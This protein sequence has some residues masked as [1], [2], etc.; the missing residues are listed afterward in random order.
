[1]RIGRAEVL[2][3]V[4]VAAMLASVTWGVLTV[5]SARDAATREQGRVEE[6]IRLRVLAEEEAAE[7]RALATS[8]ADSAEI[9]RQEGE[10]KR[11]EAERRAASARRAAT[12]AEAR[13]RGTL[14]SLGASSDALDSLVA[15]HAAEVE[16]KDSVIVAQD[17]ELVAV[18]TYAETLV[19]ALE[20]ADAR[21]Q[22]LEA[23]RDSYRRQ[24]EAWQKAAAPPLL[25]KIA[26]EAGRAVVYG[27]GGYL[28]GR[29]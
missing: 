26:R 5:R 27:A 17:R 20:K 14:D 25:T 19:A 29:F 4:L 11:L 8:W 9:A 18:R 10:Q 28:A 13:L 24:A 2:F 12:D 23:E 6:L 7:A 16:A 1:M 3:V 21:A 22:A 15:S